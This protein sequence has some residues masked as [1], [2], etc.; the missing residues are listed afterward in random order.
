MKK[1]V[2]FVVASGGW[3][4]KRLVPT[5][6]GTSRTIDGL[7]ALEWPK[8]RGSLRLVERGTSAHAVFERQVGR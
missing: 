3:P 8:L 2:A 6:S 4:L 5:L 7:A 1:Y